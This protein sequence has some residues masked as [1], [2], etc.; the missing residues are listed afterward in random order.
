MTTTT[1]GGPTW[2][3]R[4]PRVERDPQWFWDVVGAHP[5][6]APA[7]T[8]AAVAPSTWALAVLPLVAPVGLWGLYA[9][10]V[11]LPVSLALAGALLPAV[12]LLRRGVGGSAALGVVA[13]GALAAALLATTVVA[14][15]LGPVSVSRQAVQLELYQR[16]FDGSIPLDP[17]TVSVSCPGTARVWH[18][19]ALVCSLHDGARSARVGVTA[20]RGPGSFSWSLQR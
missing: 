1:L 13:A 3:L 5:V 12:V 11:A 14:L 10:H 20:S 6:E 7:P 15:R 2:P 9:L 17:A 16:V 4:V 18:Q 8:A 19:H